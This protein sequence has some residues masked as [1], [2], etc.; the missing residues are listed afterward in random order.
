MH[1]LLLSNKRAMT[2]NGNIAKTVIPAQAGIQSGWVAWIPACGLVDKVL[3]EVFASVSEA[4]SSI[5]SWEIAT[6]LRS[7]Q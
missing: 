2:E 3:F 4:I 7:S 5:R 1:S 6:S